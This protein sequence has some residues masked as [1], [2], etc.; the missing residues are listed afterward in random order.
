MSAILLET[1]YCGD[2]DDVAALALLCGEAVD[3]PDAVRVAGVAA[4][5]GCPSTA[6]AILAALDFYGLGTTPIGVAPTPDPHHGYASRY[7]DALAAMSAGKSPKTMTPE[8]L[9]RDVLSGAEDDSLRIVSIGYFNNLDAAL[10]DDPDL[11][12]RKVHTV[13]MMA[14][15]FGSRKDHLECNVMGHLECT[16]RFVRDYRGRAIYVGFE[17]GVSALTD[18]TGFP[19][20]Q[21]HFLLRAFELRS[22][23]HMRHPSWDPI[24]VDLA[25]HG[26]NEC[27]RLSKPGFVEIDGEGHTVF[28][29]DPRGN[30]RHLV[31]AASDAD[32]SARITRVVRNAAR[33]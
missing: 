11:F 10:H 9:Y 26:E 20:G 12:H 3:H 23:D 13:Y 4:N 24:T 2:C 1:D 5:V 7:L 17:C 31:F 30:A 8:A 27:Y 18:L 25:L 14:G 32:V 6:A 29:E 15:G 33:L 22:D 19:A 16:R 28:T 21:R